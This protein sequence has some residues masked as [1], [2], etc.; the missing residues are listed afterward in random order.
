MVVRESTTYGLVEDTIEERFYRDQ[1]LLR[2]NGGRS[3][4]LRFVI[5]RQIGC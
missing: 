4:I 2:V 1:C 3:E 5:S